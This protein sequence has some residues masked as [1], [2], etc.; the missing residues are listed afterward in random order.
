MVDSIVMVVLKSTAGWLFNR[1]RNR[2]V[3]R[4]RSDGGMFNH[5]LSTLIE[6]DFS[7]IKNEL[8]AG[9]RKDL[10]DSISLFE[11][12][13]ISVRYQ[14]VTSPSDTVDGPTNPKRGR[15]SKAQAIEL[16]ALAAAAV[17][18]DIKTVSNYDCN[19]TAKKRFEEA[20]QKAGSALSNSALSMS[21]SVLATGIKILATLLETEDSTLALN[22]CRHNLQ[23]IHSRVKGV[24][25]TELKVVPKLSPKKLK[26]NPE[27][28]EIMWHV[29]RLNRYVFDVAQKVGGDAFQELFI[30]PCVEISGAGNEKQE[31]DPLRD[32]RL[33]EIFRKESRESCSVVWSFGQKASKKQHKLNLPS[34]IVASSEGWFLIVDNGEPK[35]FD[36]RGKFQKSLPIRR[37][38][39]IRYHVVDGDF[40]E[41]GNLY[42]LVSLTNDTQNS[43][44]VQVFD[45]D[46][47]AKLQDNFQLVRENNY[48]ACKL[49]V[50]QNEVLVL[51]RELDRD[52]HSKIEIY[53]TKSDKCQLTGHFGEGILVDAE[54]IVCGNDRHIFVLDKC[55]TRP[56]KKCI[57]EFIQMKAND[58]FVVEY[59][60]TA[61]AF[62]RAS[63]Y[64]VIALKNEQKLWLSFYTT[65]GKIVRTFSLNEAEIVSNPSI[66]VTTKG[67]IAVALAQNVNSRKQGKVVVY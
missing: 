35:L 24:F 44:E 36:N 21:D 52:L 25:E 27:N 33:D 7:A 49:A 8:Q 56:D 38:A 39:E 54:D 26:K 45:K 13:I 46:G 62:H 18:V 64:I 10:L 22:L 51:K 12:G 53:E 48:K 57:R 55:E 60:S 20:R 43:D 16:G 50:N 14:K 58:S 1:G 17:G 31:I 2:A 63:G 19:H 6:S 32:P 15:S 65:D 42:L 29:C 23:K 59:S 9:R 37:D 28:R 47:N 30:W 40:S 41:N 3:K 34:S 67:R 5:R 11:E 4:L 61:V 66:T